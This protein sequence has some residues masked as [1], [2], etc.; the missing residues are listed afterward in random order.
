[1]TMNHQNLW[2]LFCPK[3]IFSSMKNMVYKN[4]KTFSP[5]F[6]SFK[7]CLPQNLYLSRNLVEI[8]YCPL[9][10]AHL[11][12]V[13]LQIYCWFIKLQLSTYSIPLVDQHFHYWEKGTSELILFS[14]DRR[15]WLPWQLQAVQSLSWPSNSIM[16]NICWEITDG[17]AQGLWEEVFVRI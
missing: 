3:I 13:I 12:N 15:L 2:W 9:D 4:N 6:Y 10:K 8:A 14:A 5:A 7:D 16:E 11:I 17:L 1:M